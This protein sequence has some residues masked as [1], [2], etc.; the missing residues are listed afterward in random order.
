VPNLS[1]PDISG[2]SKSKPQPSHTENAKGQEEMPGLE[3]S[4]SGAKK[5]SIKD[6]NKIKQIKRMDK[7]PEENVD[8]LDSNRSQLEAEAENEH[9]DSE[10]KKGKPMQ[11]RSRKEKSKTKTFLKKDDDDELDDDRSQL[12][13]KKGRNSALSPSM[14]VLT[15]M[16]QEEDAKSIVGHDPEKAREMKKMKQSEQKKMESQRR[17]LEK[18]EEK[19][20][21]EEEALKQQQEQQK[22][23][24]ELRARDEK[25]R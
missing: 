20:K 9:E 21:I 16:S 1:F 18:E 11:H 10:I 12:D 15:N 22:V 13:L 23:D 8:K 7:L 25:R 4:R 3:L 5:S 24:E 14:T 6:K 2:A 17:R 19:R